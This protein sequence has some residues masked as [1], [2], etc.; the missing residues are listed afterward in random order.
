MECNIKNQTK[1]YQSKPNQISLHLNAKLSAISYLI[2]L[3]F[4]IYAKEDLPNGLQHQKPNW[5]IQT[6]PNKFTFKC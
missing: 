2:E 4:G 6:K 3:K 1:P 5:T